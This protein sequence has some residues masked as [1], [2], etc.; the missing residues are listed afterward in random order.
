MNISVFF[1]VFADLGDLKIGTFSN[2]HHFE[3]Y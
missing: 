3:G 2:L 1:P